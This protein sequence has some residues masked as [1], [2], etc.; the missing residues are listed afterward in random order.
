MKPNHMPRRSRRLLPT[1]VALLLAM[2]ACNLPGAGAPTPSPTTLPTATAAAPTA[3][4]PVTPAS[5]PLTP[6]PTKAPPTAAPVTPASS[7]PSPTA[8]GPT[9]EPTAAA[10]EQAAT[11]TRIDRLALPQAVAMVNAGD[12]LNVRRSPGPD[13]PL[14]TQL[15][16]DAHGFVRTGNQQLVGDQLWA[17]LRL[18]SGETGWVNG[19]YLTEY[20]TPGAFCS[21][22]QVMML[23]EQF[24]QAITG[25]DGAGLA[26][27]VSPTHGLNVNLFHS[28]NRASYSP[29]EALFAFDSTY[30]TNWGAHPASGQPLKGAFRDMVQP[31]LLRVL[32]SQYETACNEIHL[33]SANYEYRW[34]VEYSNFNYYSLYKPGAPGNELDWRTWLVGVDYNGGRPFLVS[35]VQL[36]WEP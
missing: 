25:G 10:T 7:P 26:A 31:D 11:P 35:L 8:T 32:Q 4:A 12:V 28:G 5:L 34:P 21:D 14:L 13:A 30:E 16:P 24:I 17:E 22:P 23:L 29:D 18:P 36:F 9:R 19:A 33:G 6:A 20:V 27:L 2:L 1:C 3:A 15:P